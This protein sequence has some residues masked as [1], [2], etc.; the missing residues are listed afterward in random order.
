M[1]RADQGVID[2]SARY[3][4]VPRT[5]CFILRDEKVLLLHGAPS[6]RLWPGRYNGVGGHVERGEDVRT[7]ALRE[8]REE[9]GLEVTD[10]RLRAIIHVCPDVDGAGV[11]LFVF[12]A[13]ASTW[14]VRSSSEGELVW[15]ALDH[16]TELDL[17]E[18]LP[19]L[20]PRVLRTGPDDDPP[21]FGLYT[22]DEADRLVV[23]LAD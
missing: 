5:L 20:L 19:L 9:T 7:A 22:Y 17:V 16:L 15:V 8:I 12:T 10:L 23:R 6:K 2:A 1:G 4:V 21:L 14:E 18:D 11:L 3:L 13:R